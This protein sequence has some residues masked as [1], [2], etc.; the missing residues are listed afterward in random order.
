MAHALS[1]LRVSFGT[2][3]VLIGIC[4][5]TALAGDAVKASGNAADGTQQML[6]AAAAFRNA[7]LQQARQKGVADVEAY[8]RDAV[9]TALKEGRARNEVLGQATVADPKSY[10]VN[11]NDHSFVCPDNRVL[12]GAWVSSDSAVKED[13]YTCST[14]YQLGEVVEMKDVT[15]TPRD[16]ETAFD[17]SDYAHKCGERP[18]EDPVKYRVMVG[19]YYWDTDTDRTRHH[20]AIPQ[21]QFG[22]AQVV[23]HDRSPR[24]DEDG[25]E[26]TC[27]TNEV[28][29]GR[30]RRDDDV[31]YWCGQIW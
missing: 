22:E 21:D 23:L 28:I 20:C 6:P 26:F 16:G 8:Y 31:Y 1:R 10:N 29:I 19:R 4:A 11:E 12:T 13:K 24:Q 27:P 2:P 25:Y 30:E 7:A 17:D 15:V 5:G 9:K 14:V 18:G 3:I